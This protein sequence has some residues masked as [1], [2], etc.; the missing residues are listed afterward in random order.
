VVCCEGVVVDMGVIFIERL[1]DGECLA[2]GEQV[3]GCKPVSGRERVTRGD[4]VVGGESG[5][6]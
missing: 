4:L 6:R 1:A 5:V 2:A 3:V